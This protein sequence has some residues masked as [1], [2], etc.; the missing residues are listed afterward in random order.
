MWRVDVNKSQ[1][2]RGITMAGEDGL[3][4]PFPGNEREVPRLADKTPASTER[5]GK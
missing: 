2:D 5:K 4:F 1:L 3:S